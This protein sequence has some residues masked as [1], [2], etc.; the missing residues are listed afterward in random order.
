MLFDIK[1]GA[2]EFSKYLNI[3]RHVGDGVS[4]CI[5]TSGRQPNLYLYLHIHCNTC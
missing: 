3:T 2:E 1:L 4:Q 5:A